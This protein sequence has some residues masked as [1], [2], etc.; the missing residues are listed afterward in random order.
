MY[1]DEQYPGWKADYHDRSW[2]LSYVNVH[3][4]EVTPHGKGRKQDM[5]HNRMKVTILLFM[6]SDSMPW[7][8]SFWLAF[9]GNHI[10]SCQI[11]NLIIRL[12]SIFLTLVLYMCSHYIRLIMME[13]LTQQHKRKKYVITMVILPTFLTFAKSNWQ[14]IYTLMQYFSSVSSK[15]QLRLDLH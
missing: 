1:N 15:W 9:D 6:M 3:L 12:L 7:S 5:T 10:R 4:T 2:D 14:Y 13:R 8:S 11:F